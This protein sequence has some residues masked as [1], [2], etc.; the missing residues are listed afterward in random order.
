[1]FML[2]IPS[3]FWRQVIPLKIYLNH[4]NGLDGWS[5]E[6]IYS[7]PATSLSGCLKGSTKLKDSARLGPIF[8]SKSYQNLIHST[9]VKFWFWK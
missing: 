6:S 9:N 2:R 4:K 5:L 7:C 3:A 1:M 8:L